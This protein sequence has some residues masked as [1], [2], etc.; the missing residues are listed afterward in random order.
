MKY[1]NKH[2]YVYLIRFITFFGSSFVARSYLDGINEDLLLSAIGLSFIFI[3]F[4]LILGYSV[5]TKK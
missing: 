3:N 4:C 5:G 1:R 2:G